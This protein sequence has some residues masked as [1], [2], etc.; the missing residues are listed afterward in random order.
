M[1]HTV[2]P[3]AHRLG[4]IRDW[5]SRWFG[6]KGQFKNLL[7]QDISL[8]EFLDKRLRGSHVSSVDIERGRNA[9]RII[10]KTARPGV[11]IGRS[12]EGTTKLRAE[13]MK[14]LT[15]A[16][17]EMPASLKLDVED[18]KNPEMDAAIVGEMIAENLEKR[19]PFRRIMKQTIEKVMGT[20][21]VKGVKI[22]LGGRLDGAEMK[23]RES[24]KQG[25][26]P[27]QTYRADIDYAEET[28]Y[29]SYGTIGIKV[30]I[31]KG[32]IFEKRAREQ[33]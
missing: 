22:S 17:G 7:A 26:L 28:A 24:L 23:R 4:I 12:G 1:S 16:G 11:I 8:R 30:W 21:G 20:R 2:H 27:L 15:K 5:K 3:Y 29:L 10:V 6:K 25:R 9:L 31:Y 33:A 13:I 32:D 14:V 19:M 18:V